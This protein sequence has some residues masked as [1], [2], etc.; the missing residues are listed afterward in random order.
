[1]SNALGEVKMEEG[2]SSLGLRNQMQLNQA[3]Y[4]MK[5]GELRK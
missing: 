3:E 4:E 5:I 2:L 1:M